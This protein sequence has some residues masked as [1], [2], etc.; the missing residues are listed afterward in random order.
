MVSIASASRQSPRFASVLA[1]GLCGA[2]ALTALTALTAPAQAGEVYGQLGLPG[3]GL[4]Y[5]HPL[6]SSL[7]LRGDFT[8]LGTRTADKSESGIDYVGKLKTDR[9]GLFADWFPFQGGFRTTVGLTSNSF[10]LDLDATGKG[11]GSNTTVGSRNYVLGVNDGLTVNVKFPGI[12]PF[13]GIGWGHHSAGGWRFSADLGASIGKAKVSAVGRGQ[14]GTAAG[15]AD[16]D[17]EVADIRKG[18]G[19]IRA[20]PQ[21]SFAIG[22]SF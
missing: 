15:Q 7:T 11:N 14:L 12:T 21:I 5:A 10:K 13:V 20:L 16:V 1:R 8:T 17:L 6:S 9:V 4:G 3:A 19:D 22:Y 18:V 2:V